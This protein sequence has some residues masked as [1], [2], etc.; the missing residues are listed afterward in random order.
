[1]KISNK[2]VLISVIVGVVMISLLVFT[3]NNGNNSKSNESN[4]INDSNDTPRSLPI[5][6][7]PPI[8]ITIWG[9][10]VNSFDKAKSLTGLQDIE[11][12]KYIPDNLH[13]ESIRYTDVTLPETIKSITV[14]YMP[15]GHKTSDKTFIT[16]ILNAGGLFIIYEMDD[17]KSYK[18]DLDSWVK[19]FVA[20]APDVRRVEYVNG[21]IAVIHKGDPDNYIDAGI[22][23]WKNDIRITIRSLNYDD[24]ELERIAESMH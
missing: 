23:M 16:D 6:G 11:L 12:P 15:I 20:E 10:T 21:N 4:I 2:L 18:P 17:I 7:P 3:L 1:M 8:P 13:L 24:L 9:S 19:E 22:M 5:S 14:I